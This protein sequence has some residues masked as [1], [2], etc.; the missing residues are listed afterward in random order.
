MSAQV[1]TNSN[2]ISWNAKAPEFIKQHSKKETENIERIFKS[3]EEMI[4]TLIDKKM[5]KHKVI[6]EGIIREQ[7]NTK[8]KLESLEN[9]G[10]N[11]KAVIMNTSMDLKEVVKMLATSMSEGMRHQNEQI[12][13]LRE[14]VAGAMKNFNFIIGNAFR[15]KKSKAQEGNDENE[16][17]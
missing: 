8:E 2:L 16:S 17:L 6:M 15:T 4:E 13:S 7:E 3:N 12:D 10:K 1:K 9:D 14:E 11:L 5:K